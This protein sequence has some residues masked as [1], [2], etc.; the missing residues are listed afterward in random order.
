MTRKQMQ[1][2]ASE[3]TDLKWADP[4][5]QTAIFWYRKILRGRVCVCVYIYVYISISIFISNIH[6][7]KTPACSDIFSCGNIYILYN[8]INLYCCFHA[9]GRALGAVWSHHPVLRVSDRLDK[10]LHVETRPHTRK[11]SAW[12]KTLAWSE[13]RLIKYSSFPSVY[14]L[15]KSFMIKC[16]LLLLP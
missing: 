4:P 16:T 1:L 12:G 13:K 8:K 10:E 7:L 9:D 2:S 15:L 14:Q 3:I 11:G 5:A 6:R